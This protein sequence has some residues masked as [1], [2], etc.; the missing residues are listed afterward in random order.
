[1]LFN[2]DDMLDA[3]SILAILFFLTPFVLLQLHKISSQNPLYSLMNFIGS[4]LILVTM[5]RD[6]NLAAFVCNIVWCVFSLY[7][8]LRGWSKKKTDAYQ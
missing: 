4:V 8:I 1:M 3:I 5:N 7:G 2:Y 6:F